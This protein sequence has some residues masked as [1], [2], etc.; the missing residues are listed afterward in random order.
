[1]MRL[2]RSSLVRPP[3]RSELR[4]VLLLAVFYTL[5]GLGFIRLSRNEWWFSI[6][7]GVHALAIIAGWVIWHREHRS[8]EV[9]EQD[10]VALLL[11]GCDPAR[12]RRE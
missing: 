7:F 12:R 1:M 9:S 3:A 2:L 4:A 11:R 10:P 6:A 8:A 5:A